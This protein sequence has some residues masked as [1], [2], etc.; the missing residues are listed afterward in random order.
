LA[1]PPLVI[2]H[3]DGVA[4]SL[5]KIPEDILKRVGLSLQ[6]MLRNEYGDTYENLATKDIAQTVMARRNPLLAK[7]HPKD[8]LKL[9]KEQLKSYGK[10]LEPFNRH[11]RPQ[12]SLYSWWE[13]VQQDEFGGILG[14][15]WHP[16][17]VI[18]LLFNTGITGIG[19][20]NFCGSSCLD[21]R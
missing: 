19:Y 3:K 14:V 9:L 12:E 11:F 21:G 8:A 13:Q 17:Q 15:S 16:F 10:R 4:S 7:T 1:I 5:L 6:K 20:E 18:I 2:R